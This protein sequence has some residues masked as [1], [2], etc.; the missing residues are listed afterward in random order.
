VQRER[1]IYLG[2]G[3]RLAQRGGRH[4]H[5]SWAR[6]VRLDI[7]KINSRIEKGCSLDGDDVAS[8]GVLN[9]FGVGLDLQ[10]LH[11]VVFVRS[12]CARGYFQH[13]SCLFHSAALRQ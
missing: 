12:D 4:P 6:F 1:L 7:G 10:K 13:A 8:D 5:L 3:V 11:G 9:E 2:P